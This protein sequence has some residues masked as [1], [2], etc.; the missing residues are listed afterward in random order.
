MSINLIGFV[1]GFDEYFFEAL[2]LAINRLCNPPAN[3]ESFSSSDRLKNIMARQNDE[4]GQERERE[5]GRARCSVRV[6][7]RRRDVGKFSPVRGGQ[8]TVG[9]A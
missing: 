7:Q 8:R 4:T 6:M 9:P 5:R 3:Y 1:I 2:L